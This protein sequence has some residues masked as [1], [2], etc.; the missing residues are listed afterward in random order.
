MCSSS[1]SSGY[2]ADVCPTVASGT[3]ARPRG[4]RQRA[5]FALAVAVFFLV[6]AGTAVALSTTDFLQ[7]QSRVD[8][9]LWTPPAL[10]RSGA[11][12]EVAR[13]PDWSFMAWERNDGGVCVA[14]AAGQT[15]NWVRTCRAQSSERPSRRVTTLALTG[16][17]NPADRLDAIHGATTAEV[18]HVAFEL[19]N[20]RVVRVPTIPAPGLADERFFLIR[21]RFRD[22]TAVPVQTVTAYDASASRWQSNGWFDEMV[23]RVA[24]ET[25][26]AG[27]TTRR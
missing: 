9:A 22:T 18:A 20:G 11:R 19:A 23:G 14:Y 6:S 12:V 21:G 17:H 2:V 13:G 15:T 10:E 7:E 5:V 3:N 16:H 1:A 24:R 8:R 25:V 4:R 26:G 27:M